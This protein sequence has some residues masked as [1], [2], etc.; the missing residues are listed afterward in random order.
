MNEKPRF[1]LIIPVYNEERGLEDTLVALKPFFNKKL[2][3]VIMIDDG[4]TD[5]TSSILSS[6][7]NVRLITH[8]KNRGYGAALKTGIKKSHGEIICIADADGT[9]PIDK[10]FDFVNILVEKNLDM[11]VG[12]RIGDNVKIP[13]IRKPAKWFIGKLANYVTGKKIPDINSGLRVFKKTSFLPFEK[14]IPNGFSF[15]TTITLGMLS[16]GYKVKFVP[17][18]YFFRHGK[19]KIKPIRDTLNFTKLILKIGLYF[20]PLKVFMPASLLLFFVSILWVIFSKYYFGKIA[21]ISALIIIM[22]SFHLAA[23]AILA[24]LINHRLPNKYIK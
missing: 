22:T 15:T 23:L 8:D 12:A 20:A 16:N 5:K 18:N 4:S 14:I 7:E 2:F 11:I 21:D 10:I 19:S 3:E 13:I 17:I 9:Y 24:E 6:L 1:T